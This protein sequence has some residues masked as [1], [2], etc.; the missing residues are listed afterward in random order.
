MWSK[1]KQN[2]EF[3]F[4]IFYFLSILSN[5]W[6]F[7]VHFVIRIFALYKSFAVVLE[8]VLDSTSLGF[9]LTPVEWEK[10]K[11]L[12]EFSFQRFCRLKK[13]SNQ[14]SKCRSFS[15][16]TGKEDIKF[17]RFSS[18]FFRLLNERE[19]DIHLHFM[20]LKHSTAWLSFTMSFL[21]G[22]IIEM[23]STKTH[24]GCQRHVQY[25]ISTFYI[26]SSRI[27]LSLL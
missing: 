26:K 7:N 12:L 23:F 18:H 5:R 27:V 2:L 17:E 1:I 14:I 24:N 10:R 16:Q 22:E 4:K 3:N 15:F 19:N 20:C 21:L 25:V 11:V 9:V 6:T 8:L 13:S